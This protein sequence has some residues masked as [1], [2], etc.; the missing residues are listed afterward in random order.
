MI[1]QETFENYVV[2]L[3]IFVET[4]IHCVTLILNRKLA[5]VALLW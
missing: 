5:T 3:N 4:T 1:A 2:L